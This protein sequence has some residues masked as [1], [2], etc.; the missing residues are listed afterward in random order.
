MPDYTS[1]IR[2]PL[3]RSQML[4]AVELT[5]DLT[6]DELAWLDR[7][8]GDRALASL[9][10]TCTT[11]LT[12]AAESR[13]ERRRALERMLDHPAVALTREMVHPAITAATVLGPR[14]RAP[15]TPVRW[16]HAGRVTGAPLTH[17]ECAQQWRAGCV[18]VVENEPSGRY[19]LVPTDLVPWVR[20]GSCD[21]PLRPE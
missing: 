13:A 18:A 2:R 3:S 17:E 15:R 16:P 14:G 4:S 7:L 11:T 1:E 12:S 20:T 21:L 6:P 19:A 8:A 9:T 10:R 5:C